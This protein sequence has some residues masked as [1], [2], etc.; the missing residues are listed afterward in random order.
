MPRSTCACDECPKC[1]Q[2]E[3]MRIVRETERAGRPDGRDPDP[4]RPWTKVRI[5]LTHVEIFASAPNI[6][7]AME[8][9]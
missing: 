8:V 5:P 1:W 7:D 4:P 3:R 2:R 6:G 9:E